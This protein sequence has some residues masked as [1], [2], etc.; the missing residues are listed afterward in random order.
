MVSSRTKESACGIMWSWLG[1]WLITVEFGS[2][3]RLVWIC[4]SEKSRA[5][6]S[7][8]RERERELEILRE[9]KTKEKNVRGKM[10]KIM[11]VKMRE[12]EKQW[13]LLREKNTEKSKKEKWE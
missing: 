4:P 7:K 5:W 12:C 6:S 8:M 3:Y 9:D 11:R 13:E 2:G 10:R 1:E